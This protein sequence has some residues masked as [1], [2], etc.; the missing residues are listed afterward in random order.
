MSAAAFSTAIS[1]VSPVNRLRNSTTPSVQPGGQLHGTYTG[2]VVLVSDHHVGVERRHPRRPPQ[3]Q[4]VMVL[5]SDHGHQPGHADAVGTHGQAYRL[6][7]LAKHVG[8]K[9][10]GV[11]E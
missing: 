1:R 9:S 6:D 10:V 4:L 5:F 2:R 7:V 11:L 3:P 8:M